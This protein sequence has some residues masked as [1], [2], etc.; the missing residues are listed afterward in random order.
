M[1]LGYVFCQLPDSDRL[2][3]T[4]QAL[5]GP[6]DTLLQRARHSLGA[7]RAVYERPQIEPI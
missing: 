5:G 7:F 6:Q 1:G 3:R 4:E 2:G